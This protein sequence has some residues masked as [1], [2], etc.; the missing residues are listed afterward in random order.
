LSKFTLVNAQREIRVK[1]INCI[2]GLLNLAIK[3]GEILGDS[4]KHVLECLSKIDS[5]RALGL[6]E[7]TDA[8]F[9]Q[10]E[11]VVL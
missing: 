7:T 1:N 6:G 11:S 4:W 3:D 5:M 10:Q 2:R 9:F 8:E